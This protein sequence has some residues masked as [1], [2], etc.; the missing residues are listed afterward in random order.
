MHMLGER[1]GD[2]RR[3]HVFVDKDSDHWRWID[4]DYNFEF[5]ENPYGLDLFGLGNILAYVVARGDIT[6]HWIKQN[7]PQACDSLDGDDFSPVI[8]IRVMNLKKVFPYLPERLNRVLM[9]FAA[10]SRVFYQRVEELLEELLPAIEELPKGG[11]KEG[12]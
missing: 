5:R 3:D 11:D 4:F 12:A 2:V 8:K 9:H 6:R 1:H 10:G 7:R